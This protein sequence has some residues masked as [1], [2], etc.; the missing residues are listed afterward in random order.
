MD[1]L[2]KEYKRLLSAKQDVIRQLFKIE[3][4]IN[5]WKDKK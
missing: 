4:Q 1:E 2:M 5:E 3:K